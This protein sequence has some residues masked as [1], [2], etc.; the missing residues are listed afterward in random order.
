M[1]RHR[2]RLHE[3]QFAVV[4]DYEMRPLRNILSRTRFK[5]KDLDLGIGSILETGYLLLTLHRPSL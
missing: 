4:W 5:L 1:E 3:A 2:Q